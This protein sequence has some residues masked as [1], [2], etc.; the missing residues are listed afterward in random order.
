[1]IPASSGQMGRVDKQSSGFTFELECWPALRTVQIT[2]LFYDAAYLAKACQDHVT[3]RRERAFSYTR[4]WR[5]VGL[6]GL[7]GQ[8]GS[9]LKVPEFL[10]VS[11][12]GLPDR[13]LIMRNNSRP[14]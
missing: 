7:E 3:A 8:F 2:N 11:R 9:A 14:A 6:V 5:V 10:G 13:S 4:V 12:A 1:M